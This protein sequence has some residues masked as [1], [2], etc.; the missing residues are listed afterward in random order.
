MTSIMFRE[1]KDRIIKKA[2]A[3]AFWVTVWFIV[4]LFTDNRLLVASP[5][6]TFKALTGLLIDVGFYKAVTGS[7]LRIMSGLIIGVASGVVSAVCAYRYEWFGEL[8][9]P[10]VNMC[11][12]VPVAV[13]AVILLIWWG[14]SELALAVSAIVVYPGMY[15][16]TLE[17]LKSCDVSMLE[18]ARIFDMP[19]KNK[20]WYIYRPALKS[21]IMSSIKTLTGMSW[22]AGVAAEVIGLTGSSVGER[23]Y[24]SKIYLD[25]AGVFAWAAVVVFISFLCET[26]VVKCADILFKVTPQCVAKK[27]GEAAAV[28]DKPAVIADRVSKSFGERV[29]FDSLTCTFEGRDNI[30]S[31]PSGSGKTTLLRMIAGLEKPDAGSIITCGTVAMVFQEDRLSEDYTPVVNVMMVGI[32]EDRARRALLEVLDED[33]LNK[34]CRELSG[35]MKRRVAIVRA[36][37]SDA[38]ILLMDEPY[39]GMDKNTINRVLKYIKAGFKGKTLITA[40]HI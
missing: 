16:N 10:F 27:K 37:E 13:F 40:T 31:E 9:T 5:Y 26:V 11:K 2:V 22:K 4:A 14:P 32:E 23:L 38:D 6:D 20:L 29:I 15:Y 7:L 36:V 35:G 3:V 18:M 24:T 28:D 25:T 30:L 8:M 33:A 1:S 39:T 12:T 19:V 34:P 21:Y 17:G